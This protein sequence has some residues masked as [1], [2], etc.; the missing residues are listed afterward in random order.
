MVRNSKNTYNYNL[1]I[2]QTVISIQILII[3]K[4][5]K[6]SDILFWFWAYKKVWHLFLK[7]ESKHSRFKLNLE[8]IKARNSYETLTIIKQN[9]MQTIFNEVRKQFQ[10]LLSPYIIQEHVKYL[11]GVQSTDNMQEAPNI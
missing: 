6:K 3:L 7:S 4:H 9:N 8:F 2:S 5:E 10:K 11:N 1:D